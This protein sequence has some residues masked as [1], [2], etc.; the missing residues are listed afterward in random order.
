M[1]TFASDK[2]V[3]ATPEV[4]L[5]SNCNSPAELPAPDNLI[6]LS[7]GEYKLPVAAPSL[8]LDT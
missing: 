3:I 7:A 5:G 4:E 2:I 8:A 6:S 1:P